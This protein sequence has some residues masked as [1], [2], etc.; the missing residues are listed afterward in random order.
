MKV[1]QKRYFYSKNKVQPKMSSDECK[2]EDS[3]L[4]SFNDDVLA[5]LKNIWKTTDCETSRLLLFK[6]MNNSTEKILIY[7]FDHLTKIVKKYNSDISV[8]SICEKV[9]NIQRIN[10]TE[11]KNI[12]F[13]KKE[14]TDLPV[15]VLP[16]APEKP[17]NHTFNDGIYLGV[18]IIVIVIFFLGALVCYIT[19]IR[20]S[21][22]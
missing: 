1:N 10:E 9:E 2:N 14:D 11:E 3:E 12:R 19:P 15:E 13:P 6:R 8:F 7:V 5:A 17:N 22:F 18:V 21:N 4:A 16:E 20:V